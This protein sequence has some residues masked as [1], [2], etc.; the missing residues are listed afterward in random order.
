MTEF[1]RIKSFNLEMYNE[2]VEVL[3]RVIYILCDYFDRC[4]TFGMKA[5][6]APEFIKEWFTHPEAIYSDAFTFK[7]IREVTYIGD[8]I[9]G[10]GDVITSIVNSIH[11]VIKL[12][13]YIKTWYGKLFTFIDNLQEDWQEGEVICKTKNAEWLIMKECIEWE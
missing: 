9:M 10:V 12:L 4:A 6:Y 13:P 1:K 3:D 8:G 5:E 7:S 2:K 11:N